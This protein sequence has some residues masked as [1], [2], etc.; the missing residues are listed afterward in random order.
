MTK[1]IRCHITTWRDPLN[2]WYA[3]LT[4]SEIFWYRI[5]GYI[6]AEVG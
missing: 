3:E 6:V 2:G 1:R 4:A 5:T